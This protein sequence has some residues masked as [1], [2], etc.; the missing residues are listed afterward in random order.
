MLAAGAGTPSRA[1]GGA[2]QCVVARRCGSPSAD[3][4]DDR[5]QR[6]RQP[7]RRDGPPARLGAAGARATWTSRSSRSSRAGRS[8]LRGWSWSC[9]RSRLLGLRRPRPRA[10]RAAAPGPPLGLTAA[11]VARMVPLAAAD[12]AALREAAS[13]AAP[14]RRPGGGGAGPPAGRGLARPRRGRRRHAR[15]ARHAPGR[16]AAPRAPPSSPRRSPGIALRCFG[17]AGRRRRGFGRGRAS[18]ETVPGVEMALDSGDARL[19]WPCRPRAWRRARRAAGPPPPPRPATDW[20]ARWLSRCSA[21]RASLLLPQAR[22]ARPS[23]GSTCGGARASSWSSA[24]SGS[25]KTTLLRAGCGLVPHFHGGEVEGE[26]EVAGMDVR[27]RAR[28]ARGARSGWSRRSPRHR[29]SAPRSRRARAAAG[30]ARRS[31]GR[32]RAGRSRRWRWRWRSPT[33]SSGPRTPSPAASCSA[34]PWRRRSSAGRA[35]CSWTSRPRS[36]TRWPATS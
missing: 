17:V 24:A 1:G 13:C 35:W 23:A 34:S 8:A 3:D 25:G 10:A 26:L 33:C 11:L 9:S 30:A 31:T 22:R 7:S 18:F 29:W 6:P 19:A 21:A 15:A 12:L 5:R 4:R 2:G 32:Q 27:A 36:S 14:A 28:R 20:G 16:H